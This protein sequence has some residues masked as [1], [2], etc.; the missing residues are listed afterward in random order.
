MRTGEVRVGIG[1]CL[2]DAIRQSINIRNCGSHDIFK[3]SADISLLPYEGPDTTATTGS[4]LDLAAAYLNGGA[5]FLQ[6]RAKSLA[7]AAF[8]DLA[9]RIRQI[10][11]ADTP[12][13]TRKRN[14]VSLR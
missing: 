10:A 3:I 5:R 9:S 14:S 6:I 1:Q 13:P 7:G 2:S 11:A 8:L 4:P 12:V